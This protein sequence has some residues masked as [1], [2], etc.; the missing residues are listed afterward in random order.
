MIN[1]NTMW[2]IPDPA[3]W[4]ANNPYGRRYFDLV[5]H[6][7]RA[8]I[9]FSGDSEGGK[10]AADD[11]ERIEAPVDRLSEANGVSSRVTGFPGR[12]KVMVDIDMEA[13]LV[14]TSTPGHHH[15]IINKEVSWGDYV[16]LL[17]A[18]NNCGIISDGY[19][20]VSIERGCTWLRT[21]WT[22][23]GD[24]A[25]EPVVQGDQQAVGVEESPY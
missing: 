17:K 12:H 23:K 20:N 1:F 7:Q 9:N 14:P 24:T 18:L 11:Y 2:D 22:R 25:N 16:M 13:M 4:L 10:Q 5:M 19:T 3:D 8:R 6:Q 15:L 21:P